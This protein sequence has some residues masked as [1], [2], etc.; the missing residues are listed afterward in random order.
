M[1]TLPILL[2]SLL[3]LAPVEAQQTVQHTAPNF[4][5]PY[6]VRDVQPAPL[7]EYSSSDT[8]M[9][10]PYDVAY[11]PP[12]PQMRGHYPPVCRGGYRA[13][14]GGRGMYAPQSGFTGTGVLVTVGIISM[15]F[16]AAGIAGMQ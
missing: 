8:Q 15:I 7:D 12:D 6:A 11:A 5:V 1:R 9:E 2:C 10:Q 3:V 13:H 4:Y 16:L 14:R